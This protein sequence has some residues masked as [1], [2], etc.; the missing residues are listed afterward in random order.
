MNG[1]QLRKGGLRALSST[2]STGT[3][4][5]LCAYG[6]ALASNV[7]AMILL[8]PL[9][10]SAFPCNTISSPM[11]DSCGNGVYFKK[12]L[13]ALSPLLYTRLMCSSCT[14]GG[15]LT[16]TVVILPPSPHFAFTC[17]TIGNTMMDPCGNVASCTK[18]LEALRPPLFTWP[19]CSS[20]A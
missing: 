16:S 6:G 19:M 18:G 12:G 15:A 8:S 4:C 20:C 9:S 17:N 10:Y 3:I 5:G 13:E 14:Y 2:L 11:T 1:A 7:V